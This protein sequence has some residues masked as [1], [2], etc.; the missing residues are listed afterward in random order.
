M[1]DSHSALDP[2]AALAGE[3]AERYRRG[4]RPALSEYMARYPEL[5][6]Q[7]RELFPALVVMEELGSVGGSRV[8]SSGRPA[9]TK[10]KVPEQLGEYRILREVGRGGMGVVYEAVQ[11]SLGRHVALKVLASHSLLPPVHLERFRREARAAAQL[12]HTNIV[13]VFA[14]GELDGIH[15]F[16]MQL[17]QGQGLDEVLKEVKR[18]RFK[19]DAA[20]GT[21]LGQGLARGLLSGQL[22][23][24]RD[25]SP[26]GQVTVEQGAFRAARAPDGGES[27]ATEAGSAASASETELSAQPEAEYFRSV[28]RMG[29]QVAL[30]LDHAH[31]Q[32]IL[33]RD[34]KPSNLLLDGRGTVWITDFGLAKA[35]GSDELTHSGDIVGTLRYMGPER[36]YGQ[37]DPRSDVYG[38]GVTLYELLALRPAFDD[39]SRPRLIERIAHEDPP[40][41]RT[42]DRS[43]P[44][45]LETI[46]L[47]AIAK[48][49]ARR[50]RT[51]GALAEDLRRF[52]A[53]EPVRARRVGVW[54][55]GIK[56]GKRRPALAGLLAVSAAAV[57]S[58]LAGILAHNARLGRALQESETNLEKARQAQE[59]ARLAGLEQTRQLAIAKLREA[60]ARRHS[61]QAGRR[62]DSLEALKDAVRHFRAI[63]ELDE[64]RTLELRNEAI[65]CLTLADIKRDTR[66]TPHLGWSRPIAFDPALAHY[67]ARASDPDHP[68]QRD[69]AHGHLSVRRVADHQEVVRLPGFGVRVVDAW[70]SPDGRY[71]AAHYEQDSRYFYVWDLSRRLAVVKESVGRYE[72]RLCFSWDSQRVAFERPNGSIRIYELPSGTPRSILPLNGP[73]REL[74]FL[75]D[76]RHL[77]VA[78]GAVIQLREV[79]SGK[80]V[81]AF[82]NP[83]AVTCLAWR[84]DG[85]VFATGCI[86]NGIY[87]WD[88]EQPA[89]PLRCLKGHYGRVLSVGFSH[90]G[91]LLWSDSWDSTYRLWDPTTGQQ[92]ISTPGGFSNWHQLGPDDNA[93]D[94]AW[95]VATGRECRT[96]PGPEQPRRVALSPKGRLMASVTKAGVQLWD[97]AARREG[98]KPIATV[99]VGGSMA[100]A[101]DPKGESLIT[102]SGHAGL[103]R[104]PIVPES[105]V[106]RLRIGP[107]ESLGCSARARFTG[108]DPQFTLSADGQFIADCPNRGQVILFHVQDR[109]RKLVIERP[110]L[111]HPAFSPD[112]RWLATGNWMGRGAM[113][114]DAETGAPVHSFD[115]GGQ[116]DVSAWPAFSPDAK[117]LVLGTFAEYQFWEVGSWQA[118]Y[119]LLRAD[120]GQSLG[121]IV[122]SPDGNLVALLDSVHEVRL[123]EPATGREIARL[124][125]AGCPHCFSADGTQLVTYAG[126]DGDIQ[127]WDLRRIRQQLAQLSLDWDLPPSPPDSSEPPT[128]LHVTVQTA[129]P[130]PTSAV[131]DARA[132]LERGLL[133]VL[134]RRYGS[135]VADFRRASRLDHRHLPWDEV[136]RAYT[137]LLEQHPKEGEAYFQRARAHVRLG[138]YE[139]AIADYSQAMEKAPHIP[140]ILGY[141]GMAYLNMGLR[142]RGLADLRKASDH[143]PLTASSLAWHLATAADLSERDPA[144]ALELAGQAVR[145]APDQAAYW[146]T[147]GVAQ[148]RSGAWQAALKALEEAEHR[149]P[150]ESLGITAFVQAMCHHRLGNPTRAREQYQL[151]LRWCEQHVNQQT[152]IRQEELEAFRAEAEALLGVPQPR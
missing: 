30:G 143:D 141:R 33:H 136:V 46:V 106:G 6:E 81:A 147:I 43:I 103:E 7:I 16:A 59:Q 60:Q 125:N 110:L 111:R 85:K 113:V 102:D 105:E 62:F 48:E 131:L 134:L 144:L 21:E 20:P 38:L 123:V 58:L 49:P 18:L 139:Q 135:A 37:S 95:E 34:I 17:I 92:L 83:S 91:D 75:P 10:S 41:P 132:Y 72:S 138:H 80:K 118:K 146:E 22:P 47:K 55:R 24:G 42:V 114:W 51:A 86:D 13:P 73:A 15:Y 26:E 14:V 4:E 87:V 35:E 70:F 90:N 150:G 98:D 56:W 151:A 89:Q 68:E 63:G 3:F 82:T 69:V 112:R 66:W 107:P 122:F 28:A 12:H 100:V 126:R 2:V 40:R 11:E 117:W 121:W 109:C 61:G 76:G 77:A 145:E 45:D 152:V 84:N 93:L 142:D 101:F 9:P 108:T 129:A 65:A 57:L 67:V 52:L 99:P 1:S 44:R 79:P 31:Q 130:P 115:L 50:Y 8:G 128:P 25:S 27:C 74:Q 29:M 78:Y 96:F 88:V 53:G 19:E 23:G 36:F 116:D 5:A 140:T 148:Y 94:Y 149:A 133:Y 104:W 39:P 137:R 119:R 120:A 127:V 54:E 32:G 124:P 97:L 64:Q 71:L